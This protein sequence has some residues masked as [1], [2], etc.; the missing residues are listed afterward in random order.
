MAF[1]EGSLLIAGTDKAG[2]PT[3]T[4]SESVIRF[5]DERSSKLIFVTADDDALPDGP[6]FK[7]GS[8]LHRAW[9]LYADENLAFTLPVIPSE[10]RD[11][12]T[13]DPKLPKL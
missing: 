13:C 3:Q 6:Y 11:Q 4:L 7:N 8:N 2:G 1:T 5:L 10:D 12:Y 9:R